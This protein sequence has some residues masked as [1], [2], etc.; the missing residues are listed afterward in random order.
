[1]RSRRGCASVALS[2]GRWPADESVMAR[3]QKDLLESLRFQLSLLRLA[4]VPHG[5]RRVSMG[6]D[7]VVE[8]ARLA[9]ILSPAEPSRAC[10]HR[11]QA[12]E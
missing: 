1:M 10:V 8:L 5:N 2:A 6:A 3:E 4:V 11:Q 7:A 12:A 9:E